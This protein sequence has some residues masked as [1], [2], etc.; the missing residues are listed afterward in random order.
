MTGPEFC[1]LLNVDYDAVLLKRKEHQE[2]NLRYFIEQLLEIEAVQRALEQ[3][4]GGV[5]SW[6]DDTP[7]V[8]H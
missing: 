6:D 2:E 1:K 7:H 3:Q 8:S 5:V 4:L